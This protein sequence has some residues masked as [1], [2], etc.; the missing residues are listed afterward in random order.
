MTGIYKYIILK[1][2]RLIIQFHQTEVNFEDIKNL[3]TQIIQDKDYDPSYKTLADLRLAKIVSKNIDEVHL[4]GKWLSEM[5]EVNG[6][7]SKAIITSTPNQVAISTIMSK[8]KALKDFSYN[9][10][11]TLA[12]SLSYLQIH[13]RNFKFIEN[14][15]ESMVE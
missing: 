11:S 14:T 4:Y 8:T 7:F 9:I 6:E 1:E 13:N 3:K 2:L 15:I 10:F 5:V 12:G